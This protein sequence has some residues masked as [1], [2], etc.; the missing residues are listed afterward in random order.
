MPC[1]AT[2]AGAEGGEGGVFAPCKAPWTGRRGGA[3]E[4]EVREGMRDG[5]EGVLSTTCLCVIC[6]HF[7]EPSIQSLTNRR[8]DGARTSH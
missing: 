7:T 5:V 3:M 4:W 6:M 1:I 2:A 8:F